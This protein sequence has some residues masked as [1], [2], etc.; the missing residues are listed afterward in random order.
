LLLAKCPVK[1]N[2]NIYHLS[3]WKNIIEKTYHHTTHYLIA[4]DKNNKKYHNKKSKLNKESFISSV[5]VSKNSNHVLE[6]QVVGVLPI[7]HLN[8]IMF[9]NYIISIPYFDHSGILADSNLIER[10]LVNEALLLSKKLKSRF[11]EIRQLKP[12]TWLKSRHEK[13]KCISGENNIL[14]QIQFNLGQHKNRMLLDL[15]NTPDLLMKSFKSNLRRKIRKAKKEG[16]YAKLGNI[17]LLNDFYSVFVENMRDL[18]SPVHSKNIMNNTIKE[19]PNNSKI[20]V[21]YSKDGTP[22]AAS[23]NLFFKNVFSNPWVSA[24][25]EYRRYYTNMLLYWTMMEYACSKGYDIFDFG[26]STVDEGTYKFKLQ[27]GAKPYPL[28]WYYLSP[29][30]KYLKRISTDKTVFN[31]ASRY[32]KRLP[33]LITKK[34]GPIIRKHIGL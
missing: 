17:D 10:K 8:N 4:F 6:L 18:G 13:S 15:P 23:L 26:R 20:V 25:K 19:F 27:W 32:W 28:N 31:I 11:I 1:L 2:H 9:G 24:I 16:F 34:I 29:K 22:V 5:G 14:P 7:V 30:Q 12:I 3:G 21:V 33:I